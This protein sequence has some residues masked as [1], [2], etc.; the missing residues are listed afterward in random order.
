[1]LK[2]PV[3]V[4]TRG[5]WTVNTPAIGH[6]KRYLSDLRKSWLAYINKEPYHVTPYRLYFGSKINKGA[7]QEVTAT[8]TKWRLHL[9]NDNS[10]EMV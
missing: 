8:F 4:I 6:G 7:K 10:E 5:A 9:P 1:M 3:L 2:Q